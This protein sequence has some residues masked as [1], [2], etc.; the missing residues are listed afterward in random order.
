MATPQT[1]KK[2]RLARFLAA[3]KGGNS[4][5]KPNEYQEVPIT[6]Y[7]IKVVAD[8]IL[9]ERKIEYFK[10]LELLSERPEADNLYDYLSDLWDMLQ[11][12]HS[13]VL[14][15]GGVFAT[16]GS[17]ARFAKLMHGWDKLY[18]NTV[19]KC[20]RVRMFWA[21]SKEKK[22]GDYSIDEIHIRNLELFMWHLVFPD[23]FDVLNYCF[24]SEDVRARSVTLI[25]NMMPQQHNLPFGFGPQQNTPPGNQ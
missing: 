21:N 8:G 14:R 15:I 18:S 9:E 16:A 5:K 20:I 4:D 24:K 12:T 2:S 17:D 19:S 1:E 22:M 6:G 11:T 3:V 23:A 13:C 7:A 25:Q 10:L